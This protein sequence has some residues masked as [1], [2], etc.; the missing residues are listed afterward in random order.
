ML[1]EKRRHIGWNLRKMWCATCPYLILAGLF[2]YLPLGTFGQS[3]QEQDGLC[4]ADGC[5]S[6]HLQRKTF[7]ESWRSC[8]EK[9]GNLATVKRPEEATLIHELLS[10]GERRGPRPK[11]RLWI[12]LQRQPRQCSA[13]RPLRGFTWITGDQDTQ[14][15]NWQRD[16]LPSACAAPRCVV[17]TYNT[18]DKSNSDQNN[19]K[20]LDGSCMLPVDGFLCR[21]TYRGMCPPLK[22]EG[23]GPAL[24]TTPFNLLSTLLTHIPFG[25]VAT[26]SCPDSAKGEQSVLCM[27]HEDGKIQWSKDAPLCSD[28]LKDWCEQDNGGCEHYCVNEG[29]SYHCECSENYKLGDDGQN[30]LPLDP[31]H[32]ADC[33]FDCEPSSEGYRCKCPEGYLL[34]QDGQNCLD[35][36]ECSQNPCPQICINAPGTFECRCHDGYQLSEYGEC[37]DI[38]ECKED[39]CEQSCKNSPGSYACLCYDGFS[40]LPEDPDRCDDIDECQIPGTCE[41]ICKNYI[42]GFECRCEAGYELQPDQYSCLPIEEEVGYYTTAEPADPTSLPWDNAAY[43]T[44]VVPDEI[45][46]EWLT[47]PPSMAWFPTDLG[48]FT[49][50]PEENHIT[51]RE[52]E[53]I[54]QTTSSPTSDDKPSSIT[55]A[56]NNDVESNLWLDSKRRSVAPDEILQGED[57][58]TSTATTNLPNEKGHSHRSTLITSIMSSPSAPSPEQSP[59]GKK[60]HDRSWLL[61]A[62][63]VP[64]C[65]FIVIMLALGIVYCTSCAVE[66]R[67]KSVTDCYNWTS[68]SKPA[69]SNTAKSQA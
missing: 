1:A 15:T 52:R 6:I 14:Y 21:Y 17:I 46:L 47:D 12:G 10:A 66:P 43:T 61:V 16:D 54:E 33:E 60:K 48:W 55:V 4:N 59:D 69:K 37:L 51:S 34:S 23:S 31:C 65:V 26:L 67:N 49:D 11:L 18:T 58:I 24:Y 8:K 19:F 2:F 27:L 41:Q 45:T 38:D 9:G 50:T 20:W 57:H 68:N 63:L 53:W 44:D 22:S 42:G 3:L 13:T 30:C 29:S 40:P 39:S 5:Y 25:S 32:N 36:D 7:R 56:S 64:L 28:A 35:I 62:L